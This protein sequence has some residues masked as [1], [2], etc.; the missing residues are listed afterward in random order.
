MIFVPETTT[1]C[2]TQVSLPES[3]GAA[4]GNSCKSPSLWWLWW[5]QSTTCLTQFQELSFSR[6]THYLHANIINH[7]SS[8]IIKKVHEFLWDS[9]YSCITFSNYSTHLFESNFGPSAPLPSMLR[10]SQA[11]SQ[12]RAQAPA[13]Q[14]CRS[15]TPGMVRT[16][17]NKLNVCNMDVTICWH[18]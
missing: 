1:S 5:L 11:A 15:K 17:M 3:A 14:S 2:S 8:N 18:L 7:I 13:Q 4:I 10:A 12:A 9:W 6:P 16:N